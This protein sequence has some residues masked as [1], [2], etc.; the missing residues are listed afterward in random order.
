MGIWPLAVFVQ[1]PIVHMQ[2]IRRRSVKSL[3]FTVG[4][5]SGVKQ[6]VEVF[7]QSKEDPF[8]CPCAPLGGKKGMCVCRIYTNKHPA[9]LPPLNMRS[10]VHKRRWHAHRFGHGGTASGES[11]FLS[12]TL[13]QYMCNHRVSL[14]NNTSEHPLHLCRNRI[15]VVK[16]DCHMSLQSAS[17]C[18]PLPGLVKSSKHRRF[19]LVHRSIALLPLSSIGSS[20]IHPQDVTTG[21]ELINP[22]SDAL[23]Q[24]Y[25]GQKI[26][27]QENHRRLPADVPS[28]RIWVTF[29]LQFRCV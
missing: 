23:S 20:Y 17:R 15:Q 28:L 26:V 2:K 24:G 18:T 9:G 11:K 22:K 25:G 6:T 8:Y 1:T 13:V 4:L 10:S 7:L 27:H 29:K 21:R 14:P 12:N 3:N 16:T 19:D 5:K